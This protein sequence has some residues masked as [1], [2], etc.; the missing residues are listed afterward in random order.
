VFRLSVI[1]DR[2]IFAS[3]ELWLDAL[4]RVAAAIGD[5]SEVSLQVRVKVVSPAERLRLIELATRRLGGRTGG[6]V[7]NG[8]PTEATAYGFGGAHLPE[9]D[10]PAVRCAS[11]T[12]QVGASIH[13]NAALQRALVANIDYVQFGPVFNAGS[14]PAAG[15]GLQ[16]LAEIAA[17]SPVPVVAVG[18]ITPESAPT[19]LRAGAAAVAVV[20]GVLRS[21]NPD[22]AIDAYLAAIRAA[23]TTAPVG[24]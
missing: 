18:G 15:V 22:A 11:G 4:D 17:A 10:I 1:A 12:I 8:T 13:S 24:A 9:A 6:C 3:D 7:L 23:T 5:S 16:A 2:G 21:P 14:K 20:T 19:V